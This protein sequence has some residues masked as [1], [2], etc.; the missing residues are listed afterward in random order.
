M[1]ETFAY[2]TFTTRNIG[3]VSAREQQR[4]RE[5]PIFVC[6]VGDMGG[7]AFM[8]LVRAGIGHFVIADID[9]FEISISTGRF[10]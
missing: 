4:L 5:A 1:T 8:A 3:F 6:G 2:A 10:S 7:A 9:C